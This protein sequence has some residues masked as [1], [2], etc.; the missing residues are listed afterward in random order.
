MATVLCKHP[1]MHIHAYTYT[2]AQYTC[3]VESDVA[4]IRLVWVHV[5]LLNHFKRVSPENRPRRSALPNGAADDY[6]RLE[7]A[8][9]QR[10]VS[11][12]QVNQTVVSPHGR[13][14][15]RLGRAPLNHRSQEE[16]KRWIQALLLSKWC[17]I[18]VNK[19][20]LTQSKMER[21]YEGLKEKIKGNI[22]S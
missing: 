19:A 17:C 7:F 22:L 12:L 1:L 11:V 16:F 2:H 9:W 4:H 3:W 14:E 21:R 5:D 18:C 6:R 15:T 13:A 8:A 10:S 20:Q